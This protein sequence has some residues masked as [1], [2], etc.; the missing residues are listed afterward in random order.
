MRFLS[1]GSYVAFCSTAFS[2]AYASRTGRP[3]AHESRLSAFARAKKFS[4]LKPATRISH[5]PFV[6][7]PGFPVTVSLPV[8]PV[9]VGVE[10]HGR[11]R[12]TCGELR[13]VAGWG[14]LRECPCGSNGSAPKGDR[15]SGGNRAMPPLMSARA[16]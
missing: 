9:V 11:S 6:A 15:P 10:D 4:T 12:H 3:S 5:Q 14:L 16:L 13:W 1:A 8:L 7:E 2:A